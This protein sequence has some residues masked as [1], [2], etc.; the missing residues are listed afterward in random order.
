MATKHVVDELERRGWVASGR[1]PGD[2]R[3]RSLRLTATGATVAEAAGQLAAEHDRRLRERLGPFADAAG[4]VLS[5]LESA[6]REPSGHHPPT[7]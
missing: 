3:A 4:R 6:G 5:A 1:R 7:P 2:G